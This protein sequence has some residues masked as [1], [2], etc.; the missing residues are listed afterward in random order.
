MAHAHGENASPNN[1]VFPKRTYSIFNSN[2]FWQFPARLSSRRPRKKGAYSIRTVVS[3]GGQKFLK[4]R[5]ASPRSPVW[6]CLHRNSVI[7]ICRRCPSSVF[8]KSKET[9]KKKASFVV[10][11]FLL[12]TWVFFYNYFILFWC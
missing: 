2:I 9:Q 7:R 4:S 5:Q 3:A 11:I 10:S 8:G 1:L 12:A 6:V